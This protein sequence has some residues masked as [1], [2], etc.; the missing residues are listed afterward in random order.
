[1]MEGAEFLK[2]DGLGLQPLLST[3]RAVVS[4]EEVVNRGVAAAKAG[5]PS[6]GYASSIRTFRV[7]ER[8]IV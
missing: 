3:K 4:V 8:N 2:M 7:H 6:A 5:Q 1:M